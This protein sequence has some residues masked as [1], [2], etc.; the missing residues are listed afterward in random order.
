[1][2]QRGTVALGLMLLAVAVLVQ[3]GSADD[4]WDEHDARADELWDDEDEEG[5]DCSFMPSHGSFGAMPLLF[6]AV[7]TC[8]T[9]ALALALPGTHT[10]GTL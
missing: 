3:P 1:M 5:G 9:L 2:L 4:F 10:T 8:G 6:F 7:G